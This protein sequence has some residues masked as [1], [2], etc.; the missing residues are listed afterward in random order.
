MPIPGFCR[1]DN[2]SFCHIDRQSGVKYLR[3]TT[4]SV[5]CADDP[6]GFVIQ[7][8]LPLLL[9]KKSMEVTSKGEQ[10]GGR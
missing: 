5:L 10:K 9:Q 2:L 8:T 1:T 7:L 3:K 4:H 6:K